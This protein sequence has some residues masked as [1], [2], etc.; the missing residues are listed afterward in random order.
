LRRKG[1]DKYVAED[2]RIEFITALVREAI[3]VEITDTVTGAAIR[4]TTGG[5]DVKG[6]MTIHSVRHAI[7][8]VSSNERTAVV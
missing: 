6:N 7:E 1:F 4:K 2:E 5:L 8:I 3:L